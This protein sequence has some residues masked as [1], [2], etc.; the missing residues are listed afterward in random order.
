MATTT[1][2]MQAEKSLTIIRRFDAPRE[3]VW[4]VWTEPNH[5][6]KW[7]GPQ[8]FDTRV[9]ESDMRKGGHFHYIMTGQDGVEYPAAGRISEFDPPRK[10]VT[11]FEINDDFRKTHPNLDLPLEAIIGTAEFEDLNGKCE[12]RLTIEHTTAEDRKRHENMGVVG[13]WNSSFDKME[14]YLAELL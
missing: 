11:T 2:S 14:E 12:L 9:I 8:G 7:W 5:I 4:R 1:T 3:L 10:M 13:G 6:E